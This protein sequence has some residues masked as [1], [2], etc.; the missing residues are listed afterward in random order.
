MTE[1]V[2]LRGGPADGRQVTPGNEARTVNVLYTPPLRL[3]SGPPKPP[4]WHPIRRLRWRPVPLPELP[5]PIELEYARDFTTE[6]GLPVFRLA[7]PWQPYR[8]PDL[9]ATGGLDLTDSSDLHHGLVDAM[10]AVHPQIRHDSATEWV[11]NLAWYR[12]VRGAAR[13]FGDRDPDGDDP[14]NWTPKA[15]DQLMGVRITVT[16]DG[17]RPHLENT[18]YPQ[19][20]GT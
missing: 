11:M 12:E 6:D 17:G 1:V 2:I 16:S 18:R 4:W 15:G 10:Y 20:W 3:V 5:E 13:A 14:A 7:S 9:A 19:G 8:G